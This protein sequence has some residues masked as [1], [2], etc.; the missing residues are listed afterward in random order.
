MT[1][2]ARNT[3]LLSETATV[4][5]PYIILG[6]AILVVAAIFFFTKLPDIKD[7][8]ENGR[9]GFLHAFRHK[10]LTWAVIAQ[11]F[12]VGAQVCVLSFLILF[13]SKAANISEHEAKF[14]SGAAGL[15][16]MLGRFVGT[17]LM[18]YIQPPKLLALYSVLCILLS[19]VTICGS[20]IITLH[21]VI[22]ISFF[23]SI[24]FPTIFALGIKD[25][26]A[27]TK[28]GSSLIIMS[29]VGGAVLPPILGFISDKTNNI[30]YG[31]VV[32]LLCFVVVLFFGVKGYKHSE[33]A[34]EILH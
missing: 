18:K 14:Y 17:F 28:A 27:D 31:Y 3:F 22:G 12:Y 15:A 29:I 7:E 16:F 10:H 23:M 2:Q 1:E 20:G 21:A 13:A 9:K 8:E 19:L 25:L 11:F 26:G 5:L 30:Q 6:V 33:K 32:P 4:K 24:M 34:V